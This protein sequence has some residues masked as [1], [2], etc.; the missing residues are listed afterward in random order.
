[1]RAQGMAD[2]RANVREAFR[3]FRT[4]GGTSARRFPEEEAVVAGRPEA[5]WGFLVSIH[6]AHKHLRKNRPTGPTP[7]P[8]LPP[9]PAPGSPVA[10]ETAPGQPKA[11]SPIVPT[12][13]R[14]SLHS[15]NAKARAR[16]QSSSSG[17]LGSCSGALGM[18][19]GA[20]GTG[21]GALGSGLG[22]LGIPPVTEVQ[23]EEA[24]TWLHQLGVRLPGVGS[25]MRNLVLGKGLRPELGFAMAPGP[26]GQP[27]LLEDPFRNGYV[28]GKVAGLLRSGFGGSEQPQSGVKGLWKPLNLDE[29]RRATVEALGEISRL[30]DLRRRH[31][32]HHHG[33]NPNLNPNLNP[34]MMATK[35]Q[36]PREQVE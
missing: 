10:P 6:K 22:R 1:M 21:S 32:H 7:C 23:K 25:T 15:S 2:A 28:L 4:L 26:V 29:A 9:D 3:A 35:R 5:I 20:L 14:K 30:Y 16:A 12:V 36:P 31:H 34:E 11:S 19:S 18:V 27:G 13:A 17:A 33:N 24:A 8:A